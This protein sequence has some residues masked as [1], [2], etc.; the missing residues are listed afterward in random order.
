MNNRF[1]ELDF[2]KGIAVI[3]MVIFH[4]FYLQYVMNIKKY[5]I[6][7]GILKFLSKF[8]HITFILLVGVNIV[9]SYQKW[10]ETQQNKKIY[11]KRQLMRV[12]KL[13]LAGFLITL[14]TRFVWPE[15]YV[16]FGI[17]QFLAISTLVALLTFNKL[18]IMIVFLIIFVILNLVIVKNYSLFNF[19]D[20]NPLFCFLTGIMNLQYN[21]IDHF[22]FIP[23]FP[24]ILIGMIFAKLF[25]KK[26]K[27]VEGIFD[28]ICNYIQTNK[29]VEFISKIG[30]HSFE[31]YFLHY[32]IFYVYFKFHKKMTNDTK[33]ENELLK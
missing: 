29:I 28:Q 6:Q 14:F 5:P 13:L 4:F 1:I 19:C 22:S 15:K 10:V 27:R 8:A 18:N 32:Y 25:Y 20:K 33:Y 3:C 12:L 31:I 7:S 26:N 2:L 30:K 21:S 17:F 11:Y 23:F 9:V 24:F 16:R